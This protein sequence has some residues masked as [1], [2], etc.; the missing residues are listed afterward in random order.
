MNNL[1]FAMYVALGFQQNTDCELVT[2]PV[3]SLEDKKMCISKVTGCIVN[4][5]VVYGFKGS[6]NC[7]KVTQH[8]KVNSENKKNSE[9]PQK[10]RGR[11]SK[12]RL[13][14]KDQARGPNRF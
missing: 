14:K 3:I 1:L 8:M 2:R 11:I 4:T 10:F 13:F 7:T 12:A 6:P 5:K 9:L